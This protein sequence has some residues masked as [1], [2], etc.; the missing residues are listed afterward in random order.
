MPH[1]IIVYP[2]DT[3]SNDDEISHDSDFFSGLDER[4]W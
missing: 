4:R 2:V 3:P 1:P